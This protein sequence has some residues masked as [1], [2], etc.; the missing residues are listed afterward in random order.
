VRN[1]QDDAKPAQVRASINNPNAHVFCLAKKIEVED[2]E[3]ITE[4]VM[5]KKLLEPVIKINFQT[6]LNDEGKINTIKKLKE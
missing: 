3:V 4:T 1:S 2:Y 6:L 5:G